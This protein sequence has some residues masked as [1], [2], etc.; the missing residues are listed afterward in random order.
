MGRKGK[1]SLASQPSYIV[2]QCCC[3]WSWC[4]H[5]NTPWI[6][7]AFP[8][9]RH[10]VLLFSCL[11]VDNWTEKGDTLSWA[12][13]RANWGAG[14]HDHEPYDTD[15]QVH[16]AWPR[17]V[18]ISS[19]GLELPSASPV[20]R[21]WHT[22]YA[23]GSEFPVLYCGQAQL[24]TFPAAEVGLNRKKGQEIQPRGDKSAGPR[25]GLAGGPPSATRMGPA[26]HTSFLNVVCPP[27]S[28]PSHTPSPK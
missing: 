8:G 19:C 3:P 7:T 6:G 10:V 25:S 16:G 17:E 11:L 15:S 2:N 4:F 28:S 18:A 13:S 23:L 9:M 12:C 1:K 22:D 20:A 5:R 14:K 27:L 26:C 21:T 24:S